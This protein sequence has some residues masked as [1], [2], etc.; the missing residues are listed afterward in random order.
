MRTNHRFFILLL[1]GAWLT[2]PLRADEDEIPPSRLPSALR[3]TLE[4][5]YPHAKIVHAEKN[6]DDGRVTYEARLKKG[7]DGMDLWVFS[8]Q[9]GELQQIKEDLPEQVIPQPVQKAI[10]KTFPGAKITE[11]EK[12]T[13]IEVRYQVEV[14]VGGQRREIKISPEG[15]IIEIRKK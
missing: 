10:R 5:E 6:E 14:R 1:A 9:A 3:T 15:K 8:N 4:K 13:R 2:W 12:M 11:L 7:S